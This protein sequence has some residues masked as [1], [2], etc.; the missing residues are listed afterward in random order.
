M[1][2]GSSLLTVT[3]S[4]LLCS[5]SPEHQNP[6]FSEFD[7]PFG[8]P[9]FDKIREGDYMP[10]FKEGMAQQQQEIQAIVDNTEP[11]T[12]E[13]TIE[14]MERS[15]GLLTKV[16]DVFYHM[17]SAHTNDE[18]QK[19]AKEV[20]PLL[21][22]HTD[23]I[24]LND[25]LFQRVKAVYE[26]KGALDL[27]AEQNMLLEKYYKDF[28]RGGVQ[29][30]ARKRVE[31]RKINE[32]LSLLTLKFGENILKED[33]AFELVVDREE[34]LAGLP[35]AVITAA[36]EAAAERGHKGKWVFTLH[37]PSMMPF[38]RY[39]EKR[40]L[41][42]EVLRAYISRG[43]NDD[44]LSTKKLVTDIAKLRLKKANLLGYKTHADF[45]LEENMA[46]EPK[47]VHKLLDQ[48]WEPA[49]RAAKR[50]AQELQTLI[51]E[52][53]KD[54]E[55]EAWDWRFYAEKLR[56][57][58]YDLDD[59]MLR[60][61]FSLES[62]REGAFSVASRLYGITFEERTDIPKYQEDVRVFEVKDADGS[63]IGILYT[64]YFPRASKRGGAWMGSC[65]KQSRQAG[66]EVTPVVHN[67]CNFSMPTGD[68]PALLSLEEVR[69][70]FHEFGHAL[71]GLLSNSTYR[72]LS[73]SEVATD[74]VELPSQ[75]ME[76]WAMEPDVLRLYAKHYET[77]EVIP[78]ELIERIRNAR[79]FNQGFASVEYLAAC[80]LDMDWHTI[81]ESDRLDVDRFEPQCM[82][83]IGLIPQIVVRYK[84]PYFRHIFSGGYS[85]GY[86]S[87]V[88]A[89]VL[90]TDAFQAFKETSLF[91]Q[92]TA[93]SF[94]NNIL[95][96][97][98]TEEPMTLYRRFRGAEPKVDALLKEKGFD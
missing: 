37:Y 90:D 88:W 65:R 58:K 36:A 21:S 61:Y 54:F 48:I 85:A 44:E 53:G 69:T 50:E 79:H 26:Q 30:D 86:Y 63:H 32:R 77:G 82:E 40:E 29:L 4:L 81:T 6:F 94:R 8:V 51:Y 83:R 42:E 24:R 1:L 71:H 64:D 98:G 22:K 19:I 93:N 52:E 2:T 89:E 14:A 70:L 34:D 13:N 38:L 11:P 35:E 95:A 62:V 41:R 49:L 91:D 57:A 46:K 68:K 23:D 66:I 10:A 80:Y 39:S 15:G 3:F 73:G 5:C 55:L 59:T 25:K 47:S 31:L 87:Y 9:P 75:I 72:R 56:K 28:V 16:R 18:L 60:P 43:S 33:N 17:N 45:I 67:V 74:F 27:T 96:A 7:T 12:F 76:N 97:G 20:A 78:D 84:S 92:E